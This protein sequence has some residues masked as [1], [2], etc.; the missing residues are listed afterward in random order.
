MDEP[1]TEPCANRLCA[2]PLDLSG[3]WPL[4]DLP[5]EPFYVFCNL[6]CLHIWVRDRLL[7]RREG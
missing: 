3:A 1:Y 2:K 4:L 7:Q 5:E 6:K